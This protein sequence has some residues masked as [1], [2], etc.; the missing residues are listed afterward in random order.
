MSNH[1]VE[2]ADCGICKHEHASRE[3]ATNILTDFQ[4]SLYQT[5]APSSRAEE[6]PS[7]QPIIFA[8]ELPRPLA[9]TFNQHPLLFVLLRFRGLHYLQDLVRQLERER[10]SNQSEQQ[11]EIPSALVKRTT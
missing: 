2:S 6:A 7:L 1:V 9:F 10:E 5:P 11:K 8:T 3:G 4:T